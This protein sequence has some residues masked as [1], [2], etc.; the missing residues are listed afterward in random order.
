MK[1]NNESNESSYK[2]TIHFYEKDIFLP[3]NNDYNHFIEKICNNLL[4]ISPEQ[5]NAFSLTY[6]DEDGDCILLS[7]EEDYK[8]FYNQVQNN[9]VD[10]INIEKKETTDKSMNKEQKM[11]ESID[12]KNFI[13]INDIDNNINNINQNNIDDNIYNIDKINDDKKNTNNINDKIIDDYFGNDINHEDINKKEVEKEENIENLIFYHKC[14]KCELFPII[15]VMYYCDKCKLFLC[16]ECEK[17]KKIHEHAF[18]KI[19]TKTQLNNIE[20]K[21]NDEIIQKE[22]KQYQQKNNNNNYDYNNNI[23]NYNRY[24]PNNNNSYMY[25][26]NN[27]NLPHNEINYNPHNSYYPNYNNDRDDYYED[28]NDICYLF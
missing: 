8:I 16:E 24:P 4:K 3:I 15:C 25:N 13:D 2:I 20:E 5:L 19:E 21:I 9:L 1:E 27:Y 28:D 6:N 12:I 18:L 10:K 11:E 26:R 22:E 7:T 14:S 17:K 23:Y